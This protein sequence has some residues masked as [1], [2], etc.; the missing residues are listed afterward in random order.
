M[1]VD[2][3]SLRGEGVF[4][5]RMDDE[6]EDDLDVCLSF[7]VRGSRLVD[8]RLDAESRLS[9]GLARSLLAFDSL[10]L[11]FDALSLLRFLSIART[12]CFSH[13]NSSVRSLLSSSWRLI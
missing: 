6:E 11:V 12:F 2:D 8:L 5:L 7:D 10:P 1:D 13:S 9:L 4:F 3:L